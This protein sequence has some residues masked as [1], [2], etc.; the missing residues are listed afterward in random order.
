MPEVAA[1]SDALQRAEVAEGQVV[2]DAREVPP[3]EA[4]V[5]SDVAEAQ[6]R[7]EARRAERAAEAGPHGVVEPEAALRAAV[8]EVPG[9]AV[10]ALRVVAAVLRRAEVPAA[11]QEPAAVVPLVVA[12]VFRQGRLRPAAPRPSA[13]SVREMRHLQ[14]ASRSARWS[15]AAQDEVWSWRSLFLES[16]L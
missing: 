3:Q 12:S 1:V 9:V 5:A 4:V 16:L 11:V 2:W 6:P 7:A 8:A 14:T 15:Q 10:A 13:R